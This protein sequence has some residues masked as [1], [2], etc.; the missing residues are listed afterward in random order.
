VYPNTRITI[1]I[2]KIV[3][4][5]GLWRENRS[6]QLHFTIDIQRNLKFPLNVYDFKRD[7]TARSSGI[8]PQMW[9]CKKPTRSEWLLRLS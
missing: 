7:F 2:L 6:G 3:S 8:L 1:G 9:F 4:L 5:L